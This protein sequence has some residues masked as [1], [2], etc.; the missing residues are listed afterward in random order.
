MSEWNASNYRQRK[1]ERLAQ[2]KPE[3]I[4]NPETGEDFYLRR[5]G[6]L[7]S[8]VLAGYMPNGLTTTAVEAW[9]E[10]G[11]EGMD[12]KQLADLAASLT[13]EQKAAGERETATISRIVQQM[14]VI[15]LLSN[16]IPEEVEFNDEWKAV[17]VKGLR[18]KDPHFDVGK[19]DPKDLVFDPQEL[20][21]KDTVFLIKWAKGIA[22][23]LSVKG[24]NVN[25][26]DVER[27]RKKPGR[28][29]RT[30]NNSKNI[31][32]AS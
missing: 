12:T 1:A 27:F 31:R 23:G 14:C 6:G 30:G 21:E 26:E 32:Q 25:M 8:S 2:V 13:P 11:V 29:P 4:V 7:M 10:K 15:P 17:A 19:F 22:G 5:V 9:K 24:G 16:Q 28:S 3:W 18:E 20:D